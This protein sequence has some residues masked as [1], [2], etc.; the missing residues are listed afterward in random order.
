MLTMKSIMCVTCVYYLLCMIY[1][2]YSQDDLIWYRIPQYFVD[3]YVTNFLN[4]KYEC[5]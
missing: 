3:S 4:K 2:V 1:T 5:P